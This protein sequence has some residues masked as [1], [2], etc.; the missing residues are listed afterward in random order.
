MAV[1]KKAPGT[2]T[3]EKIIGSSAATI[4]YPT[5]QPAQRS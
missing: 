1:T 4:V 3:T 5:N 2:S